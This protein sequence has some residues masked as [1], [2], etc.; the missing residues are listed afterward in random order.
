[1]NRIRWIC[2]AAALIFS[3]LI[4]NGCKDERTMI[5]KILERPDKYVGKEVKIGGEVTKSYS[6]NLILAEAGA[7]Q[8]DDGSGKIWVITKTGVPREGSLVGLKGDVSSGMKLLGQTF[9]AVVRE[10]ERKTK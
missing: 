4:V 2:L 7:Y 1:M 8:V 6:V 10:E 5:N 3:M 9:G